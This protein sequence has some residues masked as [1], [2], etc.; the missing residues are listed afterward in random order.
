MKRSMETTVRYSSY[1]QIPMYLNAQEIVK[2]LGLSRTTVYTFM[3]ADDFPAII[4]GGRRLVQRDKFFDWLKKHEVKSV[5]TPVK[6]K[7]T[8]STF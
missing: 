4:V 8:S 5:K 6:K 7:S 2:V 1:E 3:R